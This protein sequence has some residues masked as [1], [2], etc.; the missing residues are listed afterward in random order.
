M[1]RHHA[2]RSRACPLS[3][4]IAA[5]FPGRIIILA[6]RRDTDPPPQLSSGSAVGLAGPRPGGAGGEDWGA[7]ADFRNFTRGETFSASLAYS[8]FFAAPFPFPFPFSK[9]AST[10]RIS[11]SDGAKVKSRWPKSSSLYLAWTPPARI[12]R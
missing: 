2:P 4:F 7:T 8:S 5:S 6:V 10:N 12:L 3:S 1:A 9:R 11:S